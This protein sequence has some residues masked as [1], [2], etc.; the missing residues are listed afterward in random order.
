MMEKKKNKMPQRI[1]GVVLIIIAIACIVVPI[2]YYAEVPGSAESLRDFV[3]VDG[4]RD[5]NS[6]SFML[7]T[8]GI[9]RTTVLTAAIAKFSASQELISQKDLMGGSSNEEYNQIQQY[10]MD[11]SQNAAK[12]VAMDLAKIPYKMDFKG[13]YVM[14][15]DEKSNFHNKLEVGDTVFA[16]DGQEFKSSE[17]FM[18]YVKSKDVGTE[19]TIDFIRQGKKLTETGKLIELEADKKAGIGIGLVDH[20]ELSTDRDIAIDAGAIGG[21]SAGLM[22]TLQTYALLTQQDLRHG[23]EIAGTGTISFD[24]T[25]GPIGGI[26]KKVIAADREGA[27]IFFAPDYEITKEMKAEHPD[28]TTNYQDAVASAERIKTKMKIVPVRTVQDAIDYLHTLN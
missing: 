20:T 12:Q 6:G 28:L 3:T 25:V 11:S 8:V 23:K 4:K 1:A 5:T 24:G 2:P 13:V 26:D 18:N 9:R 22:F 15:V 10:Y 21:P 19:V 17:E 14:Q 16:V 27:E 7:T